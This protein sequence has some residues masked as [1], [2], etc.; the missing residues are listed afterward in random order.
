MNPSEI[1]NSNKAIADTLKLLEDGIAGEDFR[2]IAGMLRTS[3]YY[4]ALADFDSYAD[5]RRKSAE[6][7]ADTKLWQKMSMV[8]T[9]KSYFFS[10]DRAIK[11]YADNI[12]F[13]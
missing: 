1:I 5:A 2:D 11:E 10:A 7:Y 6:L 8:N 3:D 4:M 13:C 12:W 9:A